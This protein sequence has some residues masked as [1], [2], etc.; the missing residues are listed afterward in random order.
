MNSSSLRV[1]LSADVPGHWDKSCES[2]RA[3]GAAGQQFRS[4]RDQRWAHRANVQR[5][6]CE[7][8]VRDLASELSGGV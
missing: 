8:G 5:F 2:Q 3:S 4:G 1:L 7:A 6:V